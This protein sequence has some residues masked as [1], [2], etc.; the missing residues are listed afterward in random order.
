LGSGKGTSIR[1]GIQ[2][3]LRVKSQMA[4]SEMG[5]GCGEDIMG[6]FLVGDRFSSERQGKIEGW[7]RPF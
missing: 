2:R 6:E 5:N 3:V 4:K 7:I 1:I